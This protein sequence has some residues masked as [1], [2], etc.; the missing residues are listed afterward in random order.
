M[1]QILH[2]VGQSRLRRVLKIVHSEGD[3]A[4]QRGFL[5]TALFVL[6]GIDTP[7]QHIDLTGPFFLGNPGDGNPGTDGT[8]PDDY[9]GRGLSLRLLASGR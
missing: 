8:F 1:E 9:S 7:L 4:E 2:F 5:G 6:S 3:T